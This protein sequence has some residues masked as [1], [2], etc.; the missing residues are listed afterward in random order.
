[1]ADFETQDDVTFVVLGK[2]TNHRQL[3]DG[4]HRLL[5][6][7]LFAE[8]FLEPE[9]VVS[10]AILVAPGESSELMRFK[11][12]KGVLEVHGGRYN[13]EQELDEAFPDGEYVF[14]YTLSD[15]RNMIQPV[16]ISSPPGQSRI[17]PPITITLLQDGE[18]VGRNAVSPNKDIVVRWSEF[19]AGGHDPNGIADDLLFVIT[20]DCHGNRIDHSGGPF[21]DGP[22][23]TYANTQYV[24]PATRLLPGEPY[25]LSVEHAEMETGVF[26]GVPQ[27]ATWAET[28]FTEFTTKGERT[29]GREA[30]PDVSYA[31]DKGQ[32]DRP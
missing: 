28:S 2:T 32:T 3:E 13:S 31:M 7:H 17:P 15:G 29:P 22:F 25:Q 16:D 19:A 5:N 27:I 1:M 24:V 26:E 12:G 20:G 9:G 6:Y 30:C 11:R 4:S 18:A 8:I 21:G 23:L 14:S 10:D